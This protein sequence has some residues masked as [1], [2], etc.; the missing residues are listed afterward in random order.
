MKSVKTIPWTKTRNEHISRKKNNNSIH[1]TCK[2][3][4]GHERILA[5][6][7]INAHGGKRKPRNKTMSQKKATRKT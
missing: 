3:R 5:K 1:W 2:T 7:K 6:G 4:K